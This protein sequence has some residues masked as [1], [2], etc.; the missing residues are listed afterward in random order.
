MY[1]FST[2][3]KKII[4]NDKL[5]LINLNTGQWIRM[6]MTV[7]KIIDKFIVKNVPYEQLM[8]VLAD[9]EDK[10]YVA[11]IIKQMLEIEVIYCGKEKCRNQKVV[12]F[13][14]TNRCNLRCVHCCNNA[15]VCSDYELSKNEVIKILDFL[16]SNDPVN[17]IISGGEPLIRDD[18]VEIIC[19][20]RKNYDGKIT[21]MTNATLINKNNVSFIVKNIDEINI[22]IDGIDEK[23]TDRVRGKGVFKK[24]LD[25]VNLLHEEDFGNIALSMVFGDKNYH[26]ESKFIALNRRLGTRPVIRGFAE[27]G[28]GKENKDVFST[29][30]KM[31]N[32]D[33]IFDENNLQQEFTKSLSPCTCGAG[34]EK[35]LVDYKGDI[36]PC[37]WFR[38]V[39]D[40]MGNALEKNVSELHLT[41]AVRR[42]ES[43][44]PWKYPKCHECCVNYFCW[45]CPGELKEK[46]IDEE[47]IREICKKMKPILYKRIWNEVIED[48]I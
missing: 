9:E 5:V 14:V 31:K 18:F 3:V 4:H 43:F 19:Y 42:V 20:L 22:S 1:R 15:D 39:E 37:Q 12:I 2:N 40:K 29:K 41:K 16:I 34:K 8:T 10:R 23:T 33:I 28:R 13:E 24:V 32:V 25:T 36:Y 30:E 38:E 45:P 47:Q 46:A 27:M 44:Y 26:L 48:E 17:I 21:V 11:S 35:I 7:Y 6:S